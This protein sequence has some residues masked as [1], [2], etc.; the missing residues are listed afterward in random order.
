MY[1]HLIRIQ[2]LRDNFIVKIKDFELMNIEFREK[3]K[4]DNVDDL[5]S[6]ILNNIH[7][8]FSAYVT[9]EEVLD[10]KN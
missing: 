10:V 4:S 9:L 7:Y 2:F 8:K 3:H 6:E 1:S 5:K